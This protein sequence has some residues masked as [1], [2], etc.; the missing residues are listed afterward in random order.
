MR[1]SALGFMVGM[2][3]TLLGVVGAGRTGEM[4]NS[5]RDDSQAVVDHIRSIFEAFLKKDRETIRQTHAVDWVGFLG[6]STKI[7]RG[8][9]D[10][11]RGA[12]SS[13]K[14]FHGTSYELM[15][16]EVRLYGDMAVVYYTARYDYRDDDGNEHSL[17]LRS[18]DIYRRKDGEW[19]QEGSHITP[20]PSGG[21]WG[22]G[23]VNV[24]PRELSSDE[25]TDLLAAR[26]SV[27]RAFFDN[28]QQGLREVLP[29]ELIAID[30]GIEPWSNMDQTIRNA[31]DF[32]SGGS[33]LVRL[34]FPRTEILAYGPV[35]ILFTTYRFEVDKDGQRDVTS[36]RGTEVFVRRHGRWV[37]SGWHLDSGK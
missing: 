21:S 1:K 11:M 5:T 6:P 25:R 36:G 26:E 20:I 2:S 18:I 12:E 37:N 34:E 15:D 35:A 31:S 17:P 30:P 33:K 14:S 32:A 29:R 3:L 23:A 16:T 27:W 19:I 13:L 8:I 22:E 10:Y 9:E 24:E 28:D 4:S 7:E